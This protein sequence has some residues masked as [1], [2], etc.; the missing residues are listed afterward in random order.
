MESKKILKNTIQNLDELYLDVIT[1]NK[2]DIEDKYKYK[3]HT[4]RMFLKRNGYEIKT[5]VEYEENRKLKLFKDL[6]EEGKRV[7]EISKITGWSE[8]CIYNIFKKNNIDYGKLN[9]KRDS[10]ILNHIKNINLKIIEKLY[11]DEEFVVF[12]ED[13]RY[14]V[15]NYGRV[16]S[17]I[18]NIFLKWSIR[19]DELNYGYCYYNINGNH[20]GKHRLTAIHFID[21]PNNYKEVNHKDFDRGNCKWD[22]LEWCTHSYNVKHMLKEMYLI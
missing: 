15:S 16:W 21:N 18:N 22:N 10:G 19:T 8:D 4:I 6:F 9:L 3:G 2:K 14:A 20:W 13:S 5:F 17:F 11:S 1:L 12:K 7:K